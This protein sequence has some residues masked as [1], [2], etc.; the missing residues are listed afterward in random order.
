[1]MDLLVFF[2]V[3]YSHS[4]QFQIIDV[5]AGGWH[6]AAISAFNDCYVWGWNVNGQIGLPLY[7]TFET[8]KNGE[9]RCERQKCSTVFASPVI[10]NLPKSS[11][12][13]DDD[14]M[15]LQNQYHPVAVSAGTRHTVLKIDDGS[16]MVSGWNKYGQLANNEHEKDFDHFHKIGKNVGD[17]GQIICGDWCTFY[18]SRNK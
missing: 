15:F 10:V 4:V 11:S 3:L 8:E 14:S 16:I 9:K 1:M 13:D 2:M 18:I 12:G 5:A 17:D 6:S 7:E